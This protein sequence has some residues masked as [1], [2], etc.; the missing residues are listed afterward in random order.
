MKY[1]LLRILLL[2]A[3]FSEHVA[4]GLMPEPGCL[5]PNIDFWEKVYTRYDLDEGIVHNTE[6]FEIYDIVTLP[7][8]KKARASMVDVALKTARVTHKQ[9]DPNDIRLQNGI[10]SRFNKG[11]EESYDLLP[12]IMAEAKRQGLPVE[13]SIL[14][15]VES[16]FNAKAQSKVGAQGLWQLMR[17][18]AKMFGLTKKRDLLDVRKAT[19]AAL[20][21]LAHNYK[22][23]Q[24]WPFALTA[25]NHGLQGVKNAMKYSKDFCT[26]YAG[27]QGKTFGFASRNFY[28]QYLAALRITNPL[29]TVQVPGW[30]VQ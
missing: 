4:F 26:V 23:T 5:K 20:K 3:L 6:T 27:Y 10:R 11:L 25:Y 8:E 28:A 15:H 21:I 1:R 2:V 22:N 19:K 16:S 9:T 30:L 12:E 7:K 17:S 13:V 24:Q 14:P 29:Y 18:T